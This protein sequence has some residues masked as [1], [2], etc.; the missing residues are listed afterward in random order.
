ML[1]TGL[2]VIDTLTNSPSSNSTD[3]TKSGIH[4]RSDGFR[5][6]VSQ[7]SSISPS[8]LTPPKARSLFAGMSVKTLAL[9]VVINLQHLHPF[10]LQQHEKTHLDLKFP[11][12]G[13]TQH[14]YKLGYNLVSQTLSYLGH[15]IR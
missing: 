11:I 12:L 8:E 5:Y 9:N 6:I 10:L 4:P 13:I 7:P 14:E 1:H 3:V 2:F 15:R